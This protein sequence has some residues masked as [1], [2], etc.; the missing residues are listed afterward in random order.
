MEGTFVYQYQK[1]GYFSS[2]KFIHKV[3]TSRLLA[4]AAAA[5]VE[6]AAAVAAAP[7][8]AVAAAVLLLVRRPCCGCFISGG[9]LRV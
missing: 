2:E 1:A 9:W 3:N 4:A 8:S 7:T 5:S 6:G